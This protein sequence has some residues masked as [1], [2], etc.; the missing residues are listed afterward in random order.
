M[1]DVLEPV[2]GGVVSY[3]AALIAWGQSLQLDAVFAFIMG[4]GSFVLLAARLLVD[5]PTA[6]EYWKKRKT[7]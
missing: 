2:S 1:K 6:I 7:K 5:V 4:A 3:T